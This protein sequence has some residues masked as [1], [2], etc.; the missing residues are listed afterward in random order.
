M[1][2]L[3][4]EQ[5]QTVL[6]HMEITTGDVRGAGTPAPAV[7]TL[8]GEGARGSGSGVRHALRQR[9]PTACQ[10]PR[11]LPPPLTHRQ[12]ASAPTAASQMARARRT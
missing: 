5:D 7:I 8:I 2:A 11:P 1:G 6:Y 3:S 9:Q 12:T 4:R 10:P